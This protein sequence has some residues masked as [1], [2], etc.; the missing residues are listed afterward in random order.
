MIKLLINKAKS[1]FLKDD[2]THKHLFISLKYSRQ[3]SIGLIWD[4]KID[5]DTFG[6]TYPDKKEPID[7]FVTSK[8]HMR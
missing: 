3:N 2:I 7:L 6:L 4:L 8:E 5:F 1:K